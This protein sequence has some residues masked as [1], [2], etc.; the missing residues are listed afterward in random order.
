MKIMEEMKKGWRKGKND[1]R[2]A[3]HTVGL[4]NGRWSE[5]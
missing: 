1:R 5:R 4:I 3:W 2:K